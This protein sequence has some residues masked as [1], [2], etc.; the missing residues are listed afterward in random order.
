MNQLLKEVSTIAALIVGLA[1]LAV[2]VSKQGRGVEF[3]QAAGGVFNNAIRAAT[4]PFSG[5]GMG[6]S[7]YGGNP[8]MSSN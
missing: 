2:L 8:F 4:N 6:V 1:I 5:G 3:I 7:S